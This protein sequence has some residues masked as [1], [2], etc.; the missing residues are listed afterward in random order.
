MT[1]LL[2]KAS[3]SIGGL[4]G[5][6]TSLDGV[7]TLLRPCSRASFSSRFMRRSR[8]SATDMMPLKPGMFTGTVRH[9]ALAPV[10]P[11]CPPLLI[12]PYKERG[13]SGSGI[14]A[15]LQH[16]NKFSFLALFPTKYSKQYSIYPSTLTQI[17]LS[18]SYSS[19]PVVS[20]VEKKKEK[21]RKY[22]KSPPPMG[23]R[24]TQLCFFWRRNLKYLVYFNFSRAKAF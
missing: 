14:G 13:T 11:R 6:G 2:R 4:V 3:G 8:I 20:T 17:L 16:L 19:M 18:S 15:I 10:A 22:C 24:A 23:D 5:G 1:N 7:S 21:K 12:C 9:H